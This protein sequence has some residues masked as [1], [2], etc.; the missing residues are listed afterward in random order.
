MEHE[1]VFLCRWIETKQNGFHNFHPKKGVL[2][3]CK[4]QLKALGLTPPT[5]GSIWQD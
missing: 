3:S 1:L 2:D 4:E 5:G